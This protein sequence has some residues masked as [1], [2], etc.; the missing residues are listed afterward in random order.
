MTSTRKSPSPPLP[1]AALGEVV[2]FPDQPDEG[3]V[4]H[5]W[6]TKAA[7]TKAQA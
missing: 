4:P 7:L 3:A 5:E 1:V 2:R 6:A